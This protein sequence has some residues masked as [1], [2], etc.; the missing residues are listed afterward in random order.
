M[1]TH[2]TASTGDAA[3]APRMV[4]CLYRLDKMMSSPDAHH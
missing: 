2:P 1:A 4:H 3:H